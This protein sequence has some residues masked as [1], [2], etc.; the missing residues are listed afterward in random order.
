MFMKEDKK[1][2]NEKIYK[3]TL[4]GWH[5]LEIPH[6]QK[7]LAPVI[8]KPNSH[9]QKKKYYTGLHHLL[10]FQAATT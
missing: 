2:T 7:N 3:K 8:S 5:T 10:S 1:K 4:F 9:I 6:K